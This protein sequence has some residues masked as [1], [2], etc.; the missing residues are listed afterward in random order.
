MKFLMFRSQDR[1]RTS[2]LLVAIIIL[3]LATYVLT[4]RCWEPGGESWKQWAAARILRETGGFPVFSLGPLYTSYLQ[5]FQLFDYPVSI[6]LEYL[7]THL[8]AYTAIF[9]MLRSILPSTFALLLTCAWIPM[10]A[11]LEPGG[12]VAGVGFVALYFRCIRSGME[13]QKEIP[14]TENRPSVI[15]KRFSCSMFNKGYLPVSLLAAALC[16]SAFVAFLI[17]NIIGVFT[18]RRLRRQPIFTFFRSIRQTQIFPLM[19]KGG[20]LILVVLTIL[21]S[22]HRWDHNHMLTDWTYIPFPSG[23][24]LTLGFFQLGNWKYIMRTVPESLWIHQDWYFTHEKAFGGAATILQALLRKPDTVIKNVLENMTSLAQLPRFFTAGNLRGPLA[25]AFWVLLPIGFLGMVQRFKSDRLRPF[26]FSISVGTIMMVGALL[27]TSLNNRYMMALLP[28]ALLIIAHIGP[29]LWCFVKLSKKRALSLVLSS[30]LIFA[31]IILNEWTVAALF[32]RDLSF[33]S[34][35]EIWSLDILLIG[36]GII[37]ITSIYRP[38]FLAKIKYQDC[39]YLGAIAA[40][41]SAVLVFFTAAYPKGK[42]RQLEA[43]LSNQA[44]L[45]GTEPLSMAI[46]CPELLS[47]L[48]RKISV[49]TLEDTWIKGFTKVDLDKIYLVRSLPPFPDSSGKTEKLLSNLDM[50]WVSSSWSKE[51]PSVSSANFWR[52]RLH[53]APFLEK[54][55]ARGWTAQEVQ[56]YGKIYRRP[57]IETLEKV[58]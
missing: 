27:L 57:I 7:L 36:I 22:S 37:F 49:L 28:V 55:L 31:G 24:P 44:F 48:S 5:I 58:Y 19:A 32:H 18:E 30:L 10:I 1:L 11:V 45:S 54:A 3:L 43:V 12:M 53:V 26:I 38:A 9:L 51:A 34:R 13:F 4:P 15:A 46:A 42:A 14:T 39:L 29:G 17:G 52:Y 50:I 21:F 35:L 41:M 8:F 2:E 56:G 25:A 47:S 20:L 40:V 33:S 16:H 23:N 6:Q